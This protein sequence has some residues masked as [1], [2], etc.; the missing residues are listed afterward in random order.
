MAY[1]PDELPDQK[2]PAEETI[3]DQLETQVDKSAEVL[4][5]GGEDEGAR[6]VRAQNKAAEWREAAEKEKELKDEM[7]RKEWEEKDYQKIFEGMCDRESRNQLERGFTDYHYSPD[8]VADTLGLA[9]FFKDDEKLKSL[10][11]NLGDANHLVQR[12]KREIMMDRLVPL[13]E[14]LPIATHEATNREEREEEDNK[15]STINFLI[16][17]GFCSTSGRGYKMIPE[18]PYNAEENDVRGETLRA[19]LQEGLKTDAED[20]ALVAERMGGK[21]AEAAKEWL[22]DPQE[23]KKQRIEQQ[24]E[25]LKERM[26]GTDEDR[27]ANAEIAKL[28][29]ELGDPKAVEDEFQKIKKAKAEGSSYLKDKRDFEIRD[30]ARVNV[31]NLKKAEEQKP[32]EEPH[33]KDS[34]GGRIR[35]FFGGK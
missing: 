27:Y 7:E 16:H 5:N 26:K 30:M 32:Q 2:N 28:E 29:V 11:D 35:R 33:P 10:T 15:N 13:L 8:E 19:V 1:K 12:R 14:G 34:L 24:I 23:V 31:M 17:A 18:F 3:A 25:G 4:H 6:L 22:P 20:E 9:G 21:Q